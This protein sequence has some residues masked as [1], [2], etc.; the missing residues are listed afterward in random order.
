M[1][2]LLAR[3]NRKLLPSL[4]KR[5]IDPARA[6]TWQKLLLAWRYYVTV[7]ALAEN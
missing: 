4:T 6:T 1:F 2:R 7:R 5:K 3:L